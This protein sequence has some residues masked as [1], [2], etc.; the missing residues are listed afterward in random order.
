MEGTVMDDGQVQVQAPNRLPFAWNATLSGAIQSCTS[1]T[2]H[3]DFDPEPINIWNK[4]LAVLSE[5]N[6]NVSVMWVRSGLN[7]PRLNPTWVPM[8]M[9]DGD[10]SDEEHVPWTPAQVT[11][12]APNV[13]ASL[14]A[15]GARWI[16]LVGQAAVDHW[17]R[18][19]WGAESG[20]R[21]ETDGVLAVRKESKKKRRVSKLE[22]EMLSGDLR[23]RR[24]SAD[25]CKFRVGVWPSMG[26]YT[27]VIPEPDDSRW[28][29]RQ[30]VN[31]L[32]ILQPVVTGRNGNVLDWLAIHCVKCGGGVREYGRD[33]LGYC[34][35]CW[36]VSG[37]S[38]GVG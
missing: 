1:C 35:G 3:V 18:D 36:K 34:A 4:D 2:R 29:M 37:R 26:A 30:T 38:G 16:F 24:L 14:R 13:S 8:I 12:C 11:K 5:H 19:V 27:L 23:Q 22:V 6:P 21:D 15:L 7:D 32:A 28:T 31:R 9:C 25:Q 10:D 20:L 17:Q 33:G